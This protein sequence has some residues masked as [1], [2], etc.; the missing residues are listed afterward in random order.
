M[1]SADV[2]IVGGGVIGCATAYALARLGVYNV[3]ILDRGPLAGGVTGICPGGIRQQ[4]EG[5]ADCLLA[6]RSFEFY[7]QINE[8][9]Q[10]EFPFVF[11]RSG[12]LFLAESET[13]LRRFRENV[14]LQNR[15]GIRSSILDPQDVG[16][17]LPDL[18]LRGVL[19]ASYCPDD[20]FIEDCHG[21]TMAFARHAKAHGARVERAEVTRLAG[22]EGRWWVTTD[23][24]VYDAAHV[25]LAAGV[26]SQALAA[27]VGLALPIRPERRRLLFTGPVT[28]G[29]LPPLV[30]A[31][32]RAVAAKQ[33]PSGV[34]YLGWLQETPRHDDLTFVE[35]TLRAGM[36][37]VR[38]LEE[39]PVRR[40][41]AGL[42]DLTPDRRPLLGPVDGFAGIH[43][44]AGF[45]GHGFMIAPAVG[46]IVAAGVAEGTPA[47]AAFALERFTTASER[48]G[49]YI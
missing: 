8:R 11:E 49:L 18:V 34:F 3:V 7:S 4:F 44:A 2:V 5:E 22:R 26:D 21:V 15:L 27:S 10:P 32:E 1:T 47:P 24:G 29:I 12:Y 41:L 23:R 38:L 45:S 6:R 14:A 31:P 20:G 13:L 48:E 40:I 46:E 43:L 30:V 28:P 25:V 42:Y 36:T 19:G 39:V 35:E 37:L 17:L 16:R 33:L 9:L